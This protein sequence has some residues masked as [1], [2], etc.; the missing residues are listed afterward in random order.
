MVILLTLAYASVIILLLNIA[1][2]SH[3][4]WLIKA[5]AVVI[6]S[7][8]YGVTWIGFNAL[9]GWPTA[10]ELPDEFKLVGTHIIHPDK[11]QGTEGEIYIWAIDLAKGTDYRPR[12]YKIPYEETLHEEIATATRR[13]GSHKGIKVR[14]ETATGTTR[15]KPD[16]RIIFKPILTPRLPAKE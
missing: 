5:S 1:F 9:T 15:S 2:F 4:H 3:W 16:T 13:G 11:K 14:Q 6:C 10:Q 7:V 12:S 8:F